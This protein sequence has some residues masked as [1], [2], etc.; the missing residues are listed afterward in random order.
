MKKRS[1]IKNTKT[2]GVNVHIQMAKAIEARAQSMQLS[3]SNYCKLIISNWISSGKTL[4]LEERIP[5]L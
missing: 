4:R 1:G 2:I 3:T 5:D